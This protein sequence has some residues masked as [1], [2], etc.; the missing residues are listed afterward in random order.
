MSRSPRPPFA[1]PAVLGL[2]LLAA[3]CQERPAPTAPSRDAVSAAV[4]ERVGYYLGFFLGA[5][6]ETDLAAVVGLT[7]P[8]ADFCAGSPDAGFVAGVTQFVRTPSGSTHVINPGS[9]VSV[10]IFE[11]PGGIVTDPCGQ[12][13]SA[14]VVATGI[15]HASAEG[16][17]T[18]YAGPGATSIQFRMRGTVTLTSGGE[19]QLRA[20]AKIVVRPDGTLVLDEE[21]VRL[22]PL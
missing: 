21:H 3:A 15:V 11:Y 4:V 5:D 2:A 6:A 7:V 10:E 12:L 13:A 9:D 17:N 1:A 14:P 8:L 18:D 19:A 16:A 20:T 22:T